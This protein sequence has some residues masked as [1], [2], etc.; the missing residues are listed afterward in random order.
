MCRRSSLGLL[1]LKAPVVDSFAAC[2][3]SSKNLNRDATMY[4]K[5]GSSGKSTFNT[6]LNVEYNDAML[7]LSA[8]DNNAI[9]VEN[10][11]IS[12]DSTPG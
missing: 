7:Y 3:A 11:V 1:S 6:P 5:K 9:N 8:V 10:L 2:I 4:A 12:G